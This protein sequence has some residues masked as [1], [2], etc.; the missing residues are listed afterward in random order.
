MDLQVG[1]VKAH[2]HI[3]YNRDGAA[4]DVDI[5]LV[6][7]AMKQHLKRSDRERGNN[8]AI[9]TAFHKRHGR[10]VHLDSEQRYGVC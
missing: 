4:S 1:G 7:I 6:P 5:R 9:V 3:V 8:G 2:R 10:N